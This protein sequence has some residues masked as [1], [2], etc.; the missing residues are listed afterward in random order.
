V[1][2]SVRKEHPFFGTDEF[3]DFGSRPHGPK[4]YRWF[5]AEL[6]KNQFL[7]ENASGI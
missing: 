7:P 4:G 2:T 1:K 3:F 6:F 5:S